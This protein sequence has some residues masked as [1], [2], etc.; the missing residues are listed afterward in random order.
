[1]LLRL[2]DFPSFSNRINCIRIIIKCKVSEI[3]NEASVYNVY[4][5]FN[6]LQLAELAQK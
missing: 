6:L 4:A 3:N 5:T 1:M 2:Y